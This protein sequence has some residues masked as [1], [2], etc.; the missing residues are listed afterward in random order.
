MQEDFAARKYAVP[1][2]D[3]SVRGATARPIVIG[4]VNNMPDAAL[5]SVESQF[6][7]LLEAASGPRSTLLRF[8]SLPEVP[9]GPAASQHVSSNYWHISDLMGSAL[10]AL[11]VTGTE[12]RSASLR[13]EPYWQSLVELLEWAEENA[14]SS[15]WSC[16]AAHAVVLHLDGI[17]RRRRPHKCCG[18]F[19]HV[20]LPHHPL[21][22][23]IESPMC[24]P[25][26]RWNDLPMNELAAAGY[27]IL[28]W[29]PEV[30]VNAFVREGRSLLVFL[31]GH[32]EYDTQTLLREY[33][34]DVGRY[35]H[36]QQAFYPGM[37]RGYLT[38]EAMA[39][40]S[41]FQA[42]AIVERHP[43]TLAK[44]PFTTVADSVVNSWR[45]SAIRLYENWLEVV[46]ARKGAA[47]AQ[48]PRQDSFLT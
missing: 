6:S 20:V 16:L 15:I 33:R 43:D 3:A 42:E 13:D 12:P 30:G 31:Q 48:A 19:E 11:I 39:L 46:D 4:I 35:L 41:A 34:R 27:S 45:T 9:R 24:V 8:S 17:Q 25:H 26:S 10:D 29:S 22:S 21:M 2:A 38:Q 47:S 40:L 36:G 7:E 1:T 28:N 44:F 14:V 18:V 37:P 32:P 5:E 23:G